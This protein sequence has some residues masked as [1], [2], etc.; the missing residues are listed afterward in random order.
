[1]DGDDGPVELFQFG[2]AL[3]EQIGAPLG[4]VRQEPEGVGRLRV[5][6]EHDHA[7]VGV[8]LPQRL[9][10]PDAL[11][12]TGGRHADVGQHDVGQVLLDRR[13]Q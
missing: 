13:Q 6:R 8:R 4:S 5:L 7:D 9:G 1:V 3:L 10:G 11:V 12:R 2:N